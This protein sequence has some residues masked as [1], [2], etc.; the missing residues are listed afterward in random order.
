M[1]YPV[2]EEVLVTEKKLMLREEIHVAPEK[3]PIEPRTSGS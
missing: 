3:S 1:I 2:V